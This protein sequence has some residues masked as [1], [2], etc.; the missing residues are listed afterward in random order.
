MGG[1]ASIKRFYEIL[2]DAVGV[3]FSLQ[4]SVHKS[5]NFLLCIIMWCPYE[6]GEH[7]L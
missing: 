6:N 2:N 3:A 1:L 5:K 4:F 7:C